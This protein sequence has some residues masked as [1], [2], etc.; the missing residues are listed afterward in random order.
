MLVE[1]QFRKEKGRK[2]SSLGYSPKTKSKR[3]A[4]SVQ[5]ETAE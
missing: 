3:G 5:P 2:P 4:R 1:R